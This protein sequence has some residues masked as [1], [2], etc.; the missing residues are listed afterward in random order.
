M[1]S[2]K[3]K[4]PI[5]EIFYDDGSDQAKSASL[6]ERAMSSDQVI[7]VIGPYS[8]AI[9]EAQSVMPDRYKTPWITPGAAASTIFAKGYKYTF[10]NLSPVNLLGETTGEYLKSLVDSGKLKKG[11]KIA[12]AVENTDHGVD[13]AN[14]I[15]GLG[16]EKSGLLHSCLQ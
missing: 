5:K 15:R 10:G 13:Y 14:G 9:G 16:Q 8:S 1:K 7:A 11:L 12:M 2:L 3:K 4:L 6:A